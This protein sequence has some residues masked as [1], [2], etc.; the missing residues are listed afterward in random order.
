MCW[1]ADVG[2]LFPIELLDRRLVRFFSTDGC[3][4]R[5]P[6]LAGK[7]HHYGKLVKPNVRSHL[8]FFATNGAQLDASVSGLAV[9]LLGATLLQSPIPGA[10]LSTWGEMATGFR[11][12]VPGP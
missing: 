6:F 2:Y 1:L 8:R 5:T 11:K 3:K 7:C 9:A 12:R 10:P 4:R